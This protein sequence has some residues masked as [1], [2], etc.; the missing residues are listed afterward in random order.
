[1]P[2]GTSSDR[3]RHRSNAARSAHSPATSAEISIVTSAPQFSSG[4][5]SCAMP[6]PTETD[7]RTDSGPS[8]SPVEQTSTSASTASGGSTSNVTRII[9]QACRVR[10]LLVSQMYPGPEDPD[11][12]A[13]VQALEAALVDRGH[14]IERAVLDRRAGGKA[15]YLRLGRDA[16]AAGRR[17]RPDVVYAH[18]LFPAGFLA[19]L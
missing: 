13:F 14:E 15:R 8:G 18:F 1:M 12:G 16:R 9:G 6:S 10:I 4:N 5:S 3:T 7:G 17:L 19:G 2:S 11:L